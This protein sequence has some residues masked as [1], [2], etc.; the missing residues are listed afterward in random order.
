MD[1]VPVAIEVTEPMPLSIEK[2]VVLAV[3]HE[4]AEE[5]PTVIGFGEIESV[6]DGNAGA[7][8]CT[9]EPSSIVAEGL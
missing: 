8:G 7:G 3:V 6:Q 2:D 1:M 9:H 5:S 4:S